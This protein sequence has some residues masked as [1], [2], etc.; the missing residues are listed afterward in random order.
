M[1]DTKKAEE[2]RTFRLSSK[3]MIALFVLVNVVLLFE[4]GARFVYVYRDKFSFSF[5]IPG[6]MQKVLNL[7]PYEMLSPLGKNHWI[8]RPGYRATEGKLRAEKKVL[9]KV[10]GARTLQGSSNQAVDRGK[11]GGFRINADGFKG[12]ELDRS[13][14]RPRILSLGDS[15]TFGIGIPD[16]PSG[17]ERVLKEM[18]TPAE[19]INGGVEG[20]SSRNILYEIEKYKTLKPEIVTIF[21]G[22]NS[23]FNH[24]P[25]PDASENM[26]R[27]VWLV[28][29]AGKALRVLFGDP[30]A[31]AE[32]LYFRDPKPEPNADNVVVLDTY[33][34]PFMSKIETI[35]DEFEAIGT[36]V[37]LVTLPGLFT[38]SETPTPKALKIGH[39]PEYTEN[40]YVLAKLSERYN[41]ALRALAVRRGL[42]I[43]DLEQWSA[44]VFKP[45]D[46]FF[47]DSVHLTGR[48]L[49]MVGAFM[50]ELLAMRLENLRKK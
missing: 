20:Y 33:V 37:L 24:V 19:V 8:L 9:G 47:S 15:I 39:L 5:L 49:K 41:V 14:T 42:G 12:P 22:W 4:A 6:L 40:P 21:I 35:V 16:Y 11:L 45:R 30:R 36:E 32:R 3:I 18:G 17:I 23:L 38:L 34:P 10:I 13:H 1:P 26:F 43:I 29:R 7:D 28:N 2:G 46:A 27:S 50:A 25:W 48:G 31:H 44:A